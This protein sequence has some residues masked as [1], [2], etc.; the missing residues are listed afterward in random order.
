MGSYEI[1]F[2]EFKMKKIIAI[3][4][5]S[6][7][8]LALAQAPTVQDLMVI[9]ISVNKRCLEVNQGMGTAMCKC[10]AVLVSAAVAQHGLQLYKTKLGPVYD[11]SYSNCKNDP[12]PAFPSKV[13]GEIYQSKAAAAQMLQNSK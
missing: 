12:D 9:Q 4:F 10:A 8:A 6:L 5:A 11:E 13:S 7:P 1:I 2:K 3:L